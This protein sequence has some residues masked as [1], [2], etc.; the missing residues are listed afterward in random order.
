[1]NTYTCTRCPATKDG[2]RLPMGWKLLTAGRVCGSCRAASLVTRVVSLPVAEVVEW[3]GA[4]PGKEVKPWTPFRGAWDL[5]TSLTSWCQ[6]ELLK[7]DFTRTPEMVACPKL[8]A[9]PFP[10]GANLYTHW[11]ATCP[12][13]RA[14]DG[15]AGSAAQ[16]IRHVEQRWRSHP[17]FGRFA[18]LWRRHAASPTARW[19]Q[20]WVVRRQDWRASFAGDAPH[21][22]V[23]VPGGRVLLRL[24]NGSD[25][26]RDVRRFRQV[27]D[28]TA[29]GGDVRIVAKFR[30][31][32][33][34][35]V[36]VRIS[37]T[38]E[39]VAQQAGG[40]PVEAE[41][42]T[43]PENLLEIRVDGREPFVFCGDDVIGKQA[44]YDRWRHRAATDLKYEKRW[45]KQKRRRMVLS[46]QQV[47]INAQNRVKTCIEQLVAMVV[48][49]ED[50]RTGRIVPG[51]LLR[52]G[53][54]VL[55]YDDRCK[56]F[57]RRFEWHALREKMRQRCAEL[58]VRFL[59]AA[60][61]EVV[62]ET[63]GTARD[64]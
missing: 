41:C 46:N 36:M 24:D 57:V 61:A 38:F 20:P 22:S 25:W 48:G 34:V 7:H 49:H 12:F 31:G 23:T 39:A 16:M 47:A 13:R 63:P 59:H 40:E 52:N 5:A 27:V 21:L 35:G 9:K 14:F 42:R 64:A 53:V 17:E 56:S 55:H 10:G 6:L 37:A 30:D 4:E 8:D 50:K 28:G 19:P 1:M 33:L 29:T 3:V 32:V 45:P 54:S 44:A 58:G 43:T 60:S 11:N 26:R 15:A 2:K 18:V 51:Y 62:D